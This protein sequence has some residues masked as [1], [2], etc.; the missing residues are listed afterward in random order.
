MP[1]GPAASLASHFA[2]VDSCTL[3]STV[4]HQHR[5]KC[6]IHLYANRH[7]CDDLCNLLL[8]FSAEIRNRPNNIS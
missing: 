8:H 7:V 4:S 5:K 2:V 6:A 1:I 3:A